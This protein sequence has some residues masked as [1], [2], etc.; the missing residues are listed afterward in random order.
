M[1]RFVVSTFLSVL[2]ISAISVSAATPALAKAT[3]T[4]LNFISGTSWTAY[5]GATSL[6]SAQ[7]VCLNANY[8]KNC[9]G[10]ATIYGHAFPG[11][12]ANLKPIAGATWIWAPGI[13]GA[14]HPSDGAAYSF[15]KTISVAG[16][17]TAGTLYVAGDDF[18]RVRVN[19]SV[20]GTIG[21]TSNPTTAGAAQSS[22]TAFDISSYLQSGNNEIRIEDANG[23]FFSCSP[24]CTYAQNP[25]G[26]VFGGFI[27]FL[28]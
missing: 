22:L 3:P 28:P 1:R 9:P 19:G 5:D 4:R 17:P 21:S 26:V 20:V 15:V 10:G 25:A 7:N 23:T 2:V 12:T 27:K 24:D 13:S 14:T 8:P 18:A 6:G 16:T 11:W